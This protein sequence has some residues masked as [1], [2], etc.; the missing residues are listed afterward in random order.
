MRGNF[1]VGVPDIA[2]LNPGRL[3]GYQSSLSL[4]PSIVAPISA[5]M[6]SASE[7]TAKAMVSIMTRSLLFFPE[8]P[9]DAGQHAQTPLRLL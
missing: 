5:G 9:A 6:P 3:F 4:E 2:R 1:A 7:T 8:S